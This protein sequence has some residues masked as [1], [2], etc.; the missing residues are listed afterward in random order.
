MSV[1]WLRDAYMLRGETV[2]A[3]YSKNMTFDTFLRLSYS[4]KRKWVIKAKLLYL[5]GA[6][7][8]L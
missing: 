3:R 7:K 2:S 6:K 1:T 5:Q 8:W 4:T